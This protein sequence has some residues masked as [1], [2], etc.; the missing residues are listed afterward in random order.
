MWNLLQ[1]L[2]PSLTREDCELTDLSQGAGTQITM[3]ND[4]KLG[5][6]PTQKY[7]KS[8]QSE[9]DKDLLRKQRI[10]EVTSH[11][12]FLISSVFGNRRQV[13]LN[14]L[15]A[16]QIKLL[17][18]ETKGKTSGKKKKEIDHMETLSD[19][20]DNVDSVSDAE[21]RYLKLEDRTSKELQEY[22]AESSPD[23]PST[24]EI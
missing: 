6:Q 18:K 16:R 7:L 19:Y 20:S 17:R 15:M 5:P 11:R 8:R 23:W 13:S 4:G 22:S 1:W 10:S 2:Y 12:D 24:P 21:E 14:K 9:F 3:W